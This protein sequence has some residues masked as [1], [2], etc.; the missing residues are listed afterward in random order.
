MFSS[1]LMIFD[2]VIEVELKLGEKVSVT[3]TTSS[4]LERGVV[5]K[6][7]IRLSN[8]LQMGSVPSLEISLDSTFSRIAL[9][10]SSE[11]GVD[12]SV[13]LRKSSSSEREVKLKS[14]LF[15]FFQNIILAHNQG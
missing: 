11:I 13:S 6:V 14:S 2:P 1:S 5:K 7:R 9:I 3:L 8:S 15:C 10:S 12:I 4:C